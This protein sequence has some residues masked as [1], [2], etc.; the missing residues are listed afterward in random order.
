MR[1]LSDLTS[2]LTPYWIIN[3]M[4]EDLK[5]ENSEIKI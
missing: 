5:T 1:V 3:E 2:L 4:F